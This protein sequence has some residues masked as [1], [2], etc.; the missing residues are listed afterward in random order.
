VSSP[1]RTAADRSP[2]T[3]RDRQAIPNNLSHLMFR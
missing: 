2:E 3:G 1:G